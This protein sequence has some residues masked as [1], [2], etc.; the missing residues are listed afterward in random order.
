MQVF[1]K[2]NLEKKEGNGRQQGE[3]GAWVWKGQSDGAGATLGKAM[4]G[5]AKP[6]TVISGLSQL[7]PCHGPFSLLQK[8]TV[9]SATTT[10][11]T[12]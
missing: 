6:F 10:D 1:T 12:M 3:R 5:Q 8:H 9:A 4:L 7:N 2:W 11:S